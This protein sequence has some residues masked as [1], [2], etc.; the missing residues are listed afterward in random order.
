MKKKREIRNIE[1]KEKS[2]DDISLDYLAELLLQEVLF[3]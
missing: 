1:K 2:R 3:D